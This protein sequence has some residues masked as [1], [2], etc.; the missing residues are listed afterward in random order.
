MLR[1]LFRSVGFV[2]LAAAFS[3]LVVDGTRS[4]AAKQAMSFSFGETASWL[5]PAK[6][7]LVQHAFD[8]GGMLALRPVLAGLFA[9]PTW[10]VLGLSG[11]VL[12]LAGRRPPPKIGF[13]SRP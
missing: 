7:A 11:M 10:L 4:I 1:F 12:L 9:V 6:L 8:S 3:A 2:L 5:F 13:S